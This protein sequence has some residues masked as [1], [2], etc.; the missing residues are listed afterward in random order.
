MAKYKLLDRRERTGTALPR[1]AGKA[2][3]KAMET[4]YREA[5]SGAPILSTLMA[6]EAAIK[7]GMAGLEIGEDDYLTP[8][9]LAEVIR[10]YNQ[11]CHYEMKAGAV[12]DFPG[13]GDEPFDVLGVE[14]PFAVVLGTVSTSQGDDYLPIQVIYTGRSD[15]LGRWRERGEVMVFDHKTGR[16]WDSST[17]IQW[18]TAAGPK[19]YASCIPQY[20]REGVDHLPATVREQMRPHEAARLALV[21]KL[22]RVDGFCLNSITIRDSAGDPKWSKLPATE[23]HRHLVYYDQAVLDEWRS[24]T[25]RWC[26]TWLE[27]CASGHWPMNDRHCASFYGRACPYLECCSIP[28]AQR[29]LVLATDL[30]MDATWTPLDRS[31]DNGG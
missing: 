16:R 12:Y 19:G 30:Y 9:R 3:H 11:G 15:L 14:V 5:G 28:P 22:D 4:R 27:W 26:Q 23:F 18:Q 21:G 13:Y 25:L 2:F 8:T 24:D 1:D 10:Q 17:V 31:T 6:M 7:D 29:E 20:V